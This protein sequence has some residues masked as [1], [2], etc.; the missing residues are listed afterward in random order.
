MPR[1]SLGAGAI[2]ASLALGRTKKSPRD[3][4][5]LPKKGTFVEPL[6]EFWVQRKMLSGRFNVLTASIQTNNTANLLKAEFN[7]AKEHFMLHIIISTRIYLAPIL[8]SGSLKRPAPHLRW[9]FTPQ[10][11]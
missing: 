3:G 2:S 6:L 10:S 8:A 5:F 1:S 4:T 7:L 11:Y 9:N